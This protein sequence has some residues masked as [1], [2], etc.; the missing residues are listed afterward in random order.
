LSDKKK[1]NES[2]RAKKN[3]SPR[4][5]HL[6]RFCYLPPLCIRQFARTL[7]IFITLIKMFFFGIL[8]KSFNMFASFDPSDAF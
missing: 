3:I 2:V 6:P 8:W 4:N 7:E 1:K 5:I